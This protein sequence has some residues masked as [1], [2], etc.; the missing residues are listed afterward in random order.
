MIC[1]NRQFIFI[2]ISK[3][4][5]TS[6]EEVLVHGAVP[7]DKSITTENQPIPM[8]LKGK[9]YKHRML[10]DYDAE[11]VNDYFTFSI[12]RNPWDRAVSRY[13]WD[14]QMERKSVKPFDD[15]RGFILARRGLKPS[16]WNL[17][18]KPSQKYASQYD[19]LEYEGT[20]GVDK[21]WRFERLDKDYQEI[22]RRLKLGD[23]PL[24]QVFPTK[25]LPYWKYYDDETEDIVRK[26]Y[27][28]DV[29]VFNYQFGNS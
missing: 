24:P 20:V 13:F 12:V 28:D 22:A 25:H 15:F 26:A 11:L 16:H 23:V 17:K 21:V 29:R 18:K 9:L 14:R 8:K 2:H 10:K 6:L 3:T 7:D 5:G 27:I 1:H 19:Y 4:A